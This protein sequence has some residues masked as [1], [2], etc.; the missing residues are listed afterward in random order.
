[1]KILSIIGARPQFIKAAVVSKAL[2][3]QGLH[4]IVINTGQHYDYNMSDVFL[5]NLNMLPPHYNL[6][7]GSGSHATMTAAILCGCEEVM[8][9]EKP[10][11]V[12]VYGDTNSTL[13]G[14]LSAAK[15]KI[16]VA[17]VEAGIRM[18]PKDMPEEIN[19][20]LVDRIS[21]LMFCPTLRAVQN[22]R[23]EN[24]VNGVIHTGDVMLDL[25][26][27][28]KSEFDVSIVEKLELKRPFVLVTLHRD[29]NVDN[30]NTLECILMELNQVAKSF[31]IV[32]PMHPRTAKRITNFGLEKLIS[33]IKITEPLPYSSVMGLL[34]KSEFLITDSGGLQKESYFAGKRA[35]VV[36]PD[37]GWI[38]LTDARINVLAGVNEISGKINQ[39]S[40][41]GNFI[42]GIFGDGFASQKIARVFAEM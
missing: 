31:E 15:L 34:S 38:E 20:V 35:L 11:W 42:T 13:A 18:L 5:K 41:S 27:T 9:K 16:P 10:D 2:L 3:A 19:R 26:Q 29:Y 39:I 24:I 4:E 37:T 8:I 17:H 25:F 1:M 14:A 32:F 21:S 22:L 30:K 23:N 40:S 28:M 6:G 36:M 33:S 7:A 12:L